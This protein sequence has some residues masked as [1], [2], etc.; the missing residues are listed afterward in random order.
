[1]TEIENLTLLCRRHH[2]LHH[3]RGFP[4]RRRSTGAADW[5]RPD[6][7]ELISPAPTPPRPPPRRVAVA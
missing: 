1:E 3:Q 4:H 7:T 5:F 2:T 6:R